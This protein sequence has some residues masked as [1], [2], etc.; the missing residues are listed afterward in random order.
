M[1]ELENKYIDL[2]LKKCL[3][4]NISKSLFI[5]YDKINKEFVNKV[6][7]KAKKIGFQDIYLDEKPSLDGSHF[8]KWISDDVSLDLTKYGYHFRMPSHDVSLKASSYA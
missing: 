2:L 6:I 5:N 1:K 7:E 3:N 8:V 4:V